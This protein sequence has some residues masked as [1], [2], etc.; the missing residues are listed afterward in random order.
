MKIRSIKYHLKEGFKGLLKNRLM[1]LAS[2]VMVSACIF[3]LVISLCVVMDL[4][5]MLEQIE[6]TIGVSVFVGDGVTDSEIEELRSKISSFEHVIK[7]EYLSKEDALKWAEQEW[8]NKN[9]LEGL[10]EDNPFPRSFEVTLE[11]AKYQKDIISKLE[12]LQQSFE[13]EY[14]ENRTV[15]NDEENTEE[16]SSTENQNTTEIETSSEEIESETLP[17]IG[18]KDYEYKGIEKIRHS[19]T[20]S[21]ML[22]TINTTLRVIGIIVIAIMCAISVA[23]ITNTIKLTVFVRKNEINIMKYVGATDWFIRWPFIIEGILIGII[24]SVIP[25]AICWLSYD[26][27]ISILYDKIPLL[28]NMEIVFKTSG[29]IFLMVMPLA[30]LL[31]SFLGAFGSITSI[32]KHLNV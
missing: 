28:Q 31:G 22:I 13:K 9:I 11:A 1:S 21:E 10:D 17:E 14:I 18:S 6:K 19:Q 24:G 4:D 29:E 23:I 5:F 26:K 20:A 16:I 3:T 32:R 8:K 7:V 12:N 15:K 30:L 25:T 27:T 2:I